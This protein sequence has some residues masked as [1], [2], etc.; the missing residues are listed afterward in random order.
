MCTHFSFELMS[1]VVF[2]TLWFFL[3]YVK[4]LIWTLA[5]FII[6]LLFKKKKKKWAW[7]GLC[8]L[9]PSALPHRLL[10]CR[11]VKDGQ[12]SP[13]SSITCS[14][15]A[16]VSLNTI[17]VLGCHLKEMLGLQLLQRSQVALPSEVVFIT[18]PQH[19]AEDDWL[20]LLLSAV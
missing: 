19:F 15:W 13:C 6:F 10:G 2:S 14:W 11:R 9:A 7:R 12:H 5:L 8:R 20:T 16:I 17:I 3:L 1:K 4:W 18:S